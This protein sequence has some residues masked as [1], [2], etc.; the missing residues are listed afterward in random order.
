VSKF[1]KEKWYLYNTCTTT[2]QHPLTWGW[3]LLTWG[4]T[5]VWPTPMW[6]GVMKLLYLCSVWINPLYQIEIWEVIDAQQ[7]CTT[8]AQHKTHGC[9]LCGGSQ[10][11]TTCAQ[12]KTHE[13]D[14]PHR[15]HPYALCCTQVMQ[16]C[17]APVGQYCCA[18]INY[19][20]PITMILHSA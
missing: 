8:C 16:Y 3:T 9:D 2:S 13:W 11:C 5:L 4:W 17:C 20:F 14:P 18:P 1:T 10:H 12:H 15:S 6:G 19:L 7:Y